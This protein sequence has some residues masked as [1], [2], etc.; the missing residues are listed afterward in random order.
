MNGLRDI[1]SVESVSNWILA[2]CQPHRVNLRQDEHKLTDRQLDLQTGRPADRQTDR[3]GGGGGRRQ[4]VG[5]K[6]GSRGGGRR[7]EAGYDATQ[8]VSDARHSGCSGQRP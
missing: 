8:E 5:W 4:E 1:Q 6:G 3:E 2:S 7:V